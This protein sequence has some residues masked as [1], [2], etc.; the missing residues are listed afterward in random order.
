MLHAYYSLLVLMVPELTLIQL[1]CQFANLLFWFVGN[2]NAL[3]P[4]VQ[5]ADALQ[6]S[7][8]DFQPITIVGAAHMTSGALVINESCCHGD[9]IKVVYTRQTHSQSDTKEKVQYSWQRL[10]ATFRLKTDYWPLLP[11]F[12]FYSCSSSSRS[13]VP[14]GFVKEIIA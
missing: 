12:L 7:N 10:Q 4:R 11:L 2:G 13:V 14:A 6:H 8:A 5:Q 9:V 3:Q 1:I